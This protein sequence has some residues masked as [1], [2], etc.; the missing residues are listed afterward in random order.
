MLD[1]SRNVSIMLWFK[2]ILNVLP[3]WP[4]GEVDMQWDRGNSLDLNVN[5]H[6]SGMVGVY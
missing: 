1:T 5:V 6:W 3:V 4:G 2:V